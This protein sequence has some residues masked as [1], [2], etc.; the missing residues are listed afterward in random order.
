VQRSQSHG[1]RKGKG[2]KTKPCLALLS[3]R[4]KRRVKV[5]SCVI[6]LTSDCKGRKPPPEKKTTN[7][8]NCTKWKLVGIVIHPIFFYILVY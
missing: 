3:R 2:K 4:R 1:N 5:A 8:V 6:V 7:M